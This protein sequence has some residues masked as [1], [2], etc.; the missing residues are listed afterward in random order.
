[1]AQELVEKFKCRQ[2]TEVHACSHSYYMRLC[3]KKKERDKE[4]EEKGMEKER[5]REGR[6]E[7][8]RGGGKKKRKEK[9]QP[10]EHLDLGHLV[11][12]I[13]RE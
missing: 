2:G 4:E 11:S 6:K 10:F 1:V 9:D 5:E 8:R 3:Q 7:G 12:R 13:M